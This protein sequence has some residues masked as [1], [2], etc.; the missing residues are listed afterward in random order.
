MLRS[1]ILLP[2]TEEDPWLPLRNLALIP[3]NPTQLRDREWSNW[4]LQDPAIRKPL[5]RQS[6]ASL[7]D[8]APSKVCSHYYILVFP[9][10]SLQ[11]TIPPQILSHNKALPSMNDCKTNKLVGTLEI[12]ESLECFKSRATLTWALISHLKSNLLPSSVLDLRFGTTR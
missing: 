2:Q 10:L 4:R 1:T 8:P 12:V 7:S 5:G 11:F 9:G 3:S 6:G